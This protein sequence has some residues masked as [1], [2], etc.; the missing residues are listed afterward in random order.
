MR[1]DK[2]T[3]LLIEGRRLLVRIISWQCRICGHEFIS[4]YPTSK[5]G[6]KTEGVMF[7]EAHKSEIDK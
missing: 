4:D 2:K 6:C 5:C 1:R 3:V 7:R